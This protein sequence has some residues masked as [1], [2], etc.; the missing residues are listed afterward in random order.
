[1]SKGQW[2]YTK[3]NPRGLTC[4]QQETLVYL[5]MGFD[6]KQVAEKLEITI[7]TARMHIKSIYVFFNVK[8]I[9]GLMSLF[10]DKKMLAIEA[11]GVLS[12]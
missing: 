6:N 10:I 9:Y 7:R 4:R 8:N 11:K 2:K 5:L 12:V 1:M 3:E